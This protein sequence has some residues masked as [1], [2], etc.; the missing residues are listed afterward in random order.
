MRSQQLRPPDRGR[1][2]P[3]GLRP[4]DAAPAVVAA[5]APVRP[6]T[7]PAESLPTV[8]FVEITE[9]AGLRFV[10]T[11]G[12]AGAK[13]LPETM[14]SGAAF[15]DYDGDGD[16][17]ILLVNSDDWTHSGA[18]PR[19]HPGP[20]PQRRPRPVRGRDGT[21][22]SRRDLLRNGRGRGR[23][24]QRRRPRHLC[25]HACAADGFSATTRGVFRDATGAVLASRVE[26]WLT[27]AAFFDMENDGDLD[28]FV[29]RYV[30]WSAETDRALST[31]LA[32]TGQGPAYDPPTAL[33]WLVLRPRYA[34]MPAVLST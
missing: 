15:L 7:L 16:Q 4:P 33:P 9:A 26:G 14:G 17:D 6:Q 20:L 21:L 18:K 23:L 1:R 28:L 12:A 27:S 29:C 34:T 2:R 3:R 24:R 8:R 25:D 22:G 10:H 31:Q 13:L 30:D 11:N 32:G 19:S 5:V